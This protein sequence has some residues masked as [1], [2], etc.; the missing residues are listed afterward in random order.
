MRYLQGIQEA[1]NGCWFGFSDY[2][3]W[4][5]W[6]AESEQFLMLSTRGMDLHMCYMWL[7][8]PVN[9]ILSDQYVHKRRTTVSIS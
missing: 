9:L 5:C 2:G 8:G 6:R 4:C 1:W 3:I 7:A